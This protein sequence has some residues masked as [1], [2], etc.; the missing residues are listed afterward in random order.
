M[1]SMAETINYAQQ[2]QE[3]RPY[4][5][6]YRKSRNPDDYFRKHE[7]ELLLYDGA[8]EMLH[9]AKINPKTLDLDKLRAGFSQME[10]RKREL[11]QTHRAAE[12]EVR[13]MERELEKLGQYLNLEQ[14]AISGQ[15][16]NNEQS[17]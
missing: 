14:P 13:Q 1:K 3:N 8:K 12:N 4:Q 7:S 9:R 17:R 2:Y 10:Q 15:K 16:R 5:I 6:R 11:Q